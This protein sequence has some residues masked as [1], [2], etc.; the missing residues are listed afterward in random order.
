MA[1]SANEGAT[2]RYAFHAKAHTSTL[3]KPGVTPEFVHAEILLPLENLIEK[4]L[5]A[6]S[7]KPDFMGT[8]QGVVTLRECVSFVREALKD[9]NLDLVDDNA[10]TRSPNP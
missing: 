3:S 1:S 2:N 5:K 9:T 6:A 4:T 8:K 10:A 7:L